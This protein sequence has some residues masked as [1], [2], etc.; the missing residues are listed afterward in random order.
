MTS[1]PASRQPDGAGLELQIRVLAPGDLVPAT[2]IAAAGMRD[3]P[4]HV[5]AFGAQ[6][7]PRQRRL[8]RFLGGLLG[9]AQSN[10]GLLGAF[11]RGEL[12][13]VLGML[14]PGRCH[15]GPLARLRL[16]GMIA[17]GNPPAGVWRISRWLAAWMR[18]DPPE[19][20]WHLGP[21]VVA[22]DHR[23]RG[24][25]RQ[26]MTRC[27]RQLDTLQATAWLETDLAINVAFYQTLG[28]SVVRDEPVLGVR[29]WF[30]RRSPQPPSTKVQQ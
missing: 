5:R 30:M 11:V 7:G 12:V 13:G 24:V 3:N 27:C 29:N 8:H 20:H 21:L 2:A 17:L 23:R 16:G 1:S 9:Y 25:G 14:Q 4:L 18:N 6:P 26:L 22:A 10:G 19:P 15:P 28:F